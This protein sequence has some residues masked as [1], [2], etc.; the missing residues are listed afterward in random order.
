MKAKV[1]ENCG[2]IPETKVSPHITLNLNRFTNI[3]LLNKE[4][5]EICVSFPPI[6]IEIDGISTFPKKGSTTVVFAFVKPNPALQELQKKICKKLAPLKEG[7]HL[8]E[9]LAPLGCKFTRKENSFL[10]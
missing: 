3:D 1:I 5:K 2:P 6:E 10:F 4:L 7:Q 8:V 9:Y